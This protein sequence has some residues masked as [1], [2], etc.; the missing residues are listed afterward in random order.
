MKN[1]F[2]VKLLIMFILLFFIEYFI[3]WSLEMDRAKMIENM[4]HL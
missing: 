3:V 2:I 1:R 4:I